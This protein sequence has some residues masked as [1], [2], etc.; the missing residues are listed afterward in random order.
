MALNANGLP[1]PHEQAPLH[2]SKKLQKILQKK[3]KM[4][5]LFRYAC[6]DIFLFAK[7]I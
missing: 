4:I 1:F 7:F 5:F 2:S 3:L 6:F